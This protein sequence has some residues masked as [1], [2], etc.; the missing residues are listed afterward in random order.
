MPVSP[1]LPQIYE[2]RICVL[3]H[4]CLKIKWLLGQKAHKFLYKIKQTNK[5]KQAQRET[6]KEYLAGLKTS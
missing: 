6:S 1:I 4:T 3:L 5:K 2:V